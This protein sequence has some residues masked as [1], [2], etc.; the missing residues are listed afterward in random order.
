MSRWDYP[1]TRELIRLALREDI[2]TGDITTAHCIPAGQQASGR[3]F[4]RAEAILAGVELLPI[5]FELH[6]GGAQVELLAASGEAVSP[7]TPIATVQ[8]SAQAL[9]ECERTSLNFLQRLSG[10]ATLA[11]RFARE[12]AHTK[13]RV[14]DTRK[15]TPGWRRIEKLA[16]AAGGVT[17]H[18]MGLYDAVLIKNN[19]ITAA[20]GVAAA[21]RRFSDTSLPVEIEVRDR[22][23]LDQALEARATHIM[24]DNRT[25]GE[26]RAEI[27]YIAGRAVVELSG[28]ISLET[29]RS[30]AETG[31]DFVS[32]GAITHQA[33]SVDFNFRIRIGQD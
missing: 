16:A 8:G 12:V 13:C 30:Y 17:N 2:G 4:A 24:L 23:E 7:G 11:H 28:N 25:P 15:T 31:A 21:L 6:G 33:Q 10:I 26:A 5:L 32:A 27:E 19:H 18:R 1:D 22:A 14:L 20:G 9:L 3:Y 29:V